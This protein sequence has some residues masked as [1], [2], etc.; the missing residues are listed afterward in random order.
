MNV[1]ELQGFLRRLPPPGRT[2]PLLALAVLSLNFFAALDAKETDQ[3]APGKEAL[4]ATVADDDAIVSLAAYNVKADRIEDF[5]FRVLNHGYFNLLLPRSQ[6]PYIE[7]VLP[8]TAA[9]KAGLQPGDRILKSDGR[10]AGITLFS[11]DKWR[12]FMAA[13]NAEAATGRTTKWTLEIQPRGTKETQ[14]VTL[15]LPTSPPRWGSSSWRAPEGR[16]SSAMTETGPLAER[17]R[18]ILDNGIWTLIEGQFL[19]AFA[20]GRSPDTWPTGYQ[21][22]IGSVAEGGL[23]LMTVTQVGG[24]TEVL[25]ETASRALSRTVYRTSPSGALEKAWRFTRKKKG[26]IALDEARP[27]FEHELDLWATQI[28]KVS[29]RWP[30]EL[31]PGYDANA[32]FAA[33]APKGSITAAP[34]PRP[35]AEEFLKLPPSNET[36]RALFADAYGKLGAEQDEWAYTETSRNLGDKRVLVTRVDPSKSE[37]ERCV[38]LRIDG[39]PPTPAQVQEWRDDGGDVPKVL[40]DLPPLANLVDL[41]D[42]RIAKD[43]TAA[44][45]FEL[46]IRGGNPEFSSEKFQALFRVNR[47]TRGFEDITVRLRDS[48]RVAG[49]VKV[50]GADLHVQFQTLDPAHPPQPVRLKGGGAARI[51]LVKIARDFETTRTDFKRVNPFDDTAEPAQY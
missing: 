32:I 9:S 38:L 19:P 11:A 18:E 13:K 16:Q 1:T 30:L 50:T 43:E 33:L 41:R 46:P 21:W 14:T 40:G 12:K 22:A 15:S 42:L 10:S 17:C 44:I 8:N 6:A 24:H 34:P 36:Q 25:L 28:G 37:A 4:P 5:G 35:F 27:G 7:A 48:F 47:T 26:E 51:V 39:R 20:S 23:H 29:P 3:V 31:K 2:F 49:L 45:V